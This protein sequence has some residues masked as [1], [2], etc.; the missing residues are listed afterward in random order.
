MYISNIVMLSIDDFRPSNY[1]QMALNIFS[2]VIRIFLKYLVAE[3]IEE[4]LVRN[5][6][7]KKMAQIHNI[8]HLRRE[9]YIHNKLIGQHL[10][11]HP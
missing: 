2:R 5:M 9:D 8:Y 11:E 10:Y 3:D 7:V 1:F 6:F 4:Q